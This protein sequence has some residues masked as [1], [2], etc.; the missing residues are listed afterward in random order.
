MVAHHLR[1]PGR[2]LQR[3][4]KPPP[5]TAPSPPLAKPL[6]IR[7][8]EEGW[9]LLPNGT[10]L[11]LEIW[12]LSEST[13]SPTP[14]LTYSSASKTWSSAGIAPDPL[15]NF[16]SS[17]VPDAL[18]EIGPAMLRP[19]GTVFAEGATGYNDIY[20]SNTGT[21]TSGPMFP[22][23]SGQQ[24]EAMDGPSALLPDGNVLVAV[25]TTD[26]GHS[27]LFFRVQ[28]I[29][30]DAGDDSQLSLRNA[31]RTTGAC[32]CCPRVRSCT[33]IAMAAMSPC[34]RPPELPTHHGPRPSRIR[35]RR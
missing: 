5:L 4:H 14:A 19:D 2:Y 25:S 31:L 33:P 8:A 20:D 24:L 7:N 26:Y 6:T 1:Q 16:T 11:T 18:H 23:V 3:A 10:V 15:V 32:C 35:R 17:P 9:N 30:P 29:Q 22:V 28:W 12:N 34:T 13:D 27:N 21:W